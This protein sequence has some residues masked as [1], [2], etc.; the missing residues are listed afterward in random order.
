M[1]KN[2]KKQ[3][4]V[5]AVGSIDSELLLEW[6]ESETTSPSDHRVSLINTL[7]LYIILA[8]GND[9]DKSAEQAF[10]LWDFLTDSIRNAYEL[11]GDGLI[12]LF[13]Y[14]VELNY[15]KDN[16][17]PDE[18]DLESMKKGCIDYFKIK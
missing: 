7:S 18:I 8:N 3:E 4:G 6:V 2:I 12:P 11:V 13:D 17:Y 15:Q 10:H 16:E 14:A 5:D 1:G 9:I